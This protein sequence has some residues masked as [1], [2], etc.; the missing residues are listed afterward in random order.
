MAQIRQS[1]G[2]DWNEAAL[3]LSTAQPSRGGTIPELPTLNAVFYRPPP[4]PPQPIMYERRPQMM[5]MAK[6]LIL[7]CLKLENAR[8]GL[9]TSG[10][11]IITLFAEKLRWHSISMYI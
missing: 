2:E 10:S 4:P 9:K 6:R 5:K 7:V 1:T 3:S 11:T 8:V